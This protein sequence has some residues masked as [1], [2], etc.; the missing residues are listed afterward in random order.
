MADV[1]FSSRSE[2]SHLMEPGDAA[3]VRIG[4]RL[5]E[6]PNGN[7][8]ETPRH[9]WRPEFLWPPGRKG[10]MPCPGFSKRLLRAL[11]QVPRAPRNGENW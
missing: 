11:G 6:A 9:E 4:T 10:D 1:R 8:G 5:N 3:H 2:L 7:D